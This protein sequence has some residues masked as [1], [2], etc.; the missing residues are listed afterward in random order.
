M[1]T[2]EHLQG[3]AVVIRQ[4]VVHHVA[5]K[6]S[7]IISA[8]KFVFPSISSARRSRCLQLTRR[9]YYKSIQYFFPQNQL[10]RFELYTE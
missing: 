8:A 7:F 5:D 1:H 10:C 2:H 4:T 6:M 3:S 9:H